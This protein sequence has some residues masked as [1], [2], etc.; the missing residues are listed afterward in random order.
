MLC[1]NI[2]TDELRYSQTFAF[3]VNLKVKKNKFTK[4]W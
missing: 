2:K 3:F 4:F 1:P